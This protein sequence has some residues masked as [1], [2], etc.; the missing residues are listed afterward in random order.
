MAAAMAVAAVKVKT[1]L[2]KSKMD[3]MIGQAKAEMKNAKTPYNDEVKIAKAAA[4]TAKFTCGLFWWRVVAA[5][6]PVK[7]ST[8]TRIT[9]LTARK[10]VSPMANIFELGY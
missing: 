8:M 9:K 5:S 6:E 4:N 2:R 1:K 3:K 7:P 10:I